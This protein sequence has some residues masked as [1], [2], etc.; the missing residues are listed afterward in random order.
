MEHSDW[1]YWATT[2]T[3]GAIV[4]CLIVWEPLVAKYRAWKTERAFRQ[5]DSMHRTKGRD[6]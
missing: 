3:V 1:P 4:L 6:W 2:G 5:R